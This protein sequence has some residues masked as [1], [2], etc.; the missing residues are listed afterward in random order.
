MA[1]EENYFVL[2]CESASRGG[3]GG[4]GGAVYL[5]SQQIMDESCWENSAI[6]RRWVSTREHSWLWSK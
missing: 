4:V 3:G 2:G 1:T 6:C 5:V